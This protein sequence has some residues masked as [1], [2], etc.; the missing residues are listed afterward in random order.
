V[1]ART[2]LTAA[3][4]AVATGAALMATAP[5]AASAAAAPS[6][7]VSPH[8]NLTNNQM[9]TVT[10]K[11]FTAAETAKSA[12]AAECSHAALASKSIAD[13]DVSSA[14]AVP[15]GKTGSGH[16]KFK[17]L[18][19]ANYKDAN[20]GKCGGKNACIITVVDNPFAP[21]QEAAGVISFA[22]PKKATHTKVTSKKTVHKGKKVTF[23]V[24]TTHKGAGRLSGTVT[25]TANGKKIG[26][27]KESK[28]GRA[29]V[30]V[31]FK[32]TGTFT[33]KARYAGNKGFKG[34]TGKEKIHVKS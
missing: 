1:R 8:R 9:V 4:M 2:T 25:F 3:A 23:T 30:S 11:G 6:V 18:T 15:I 27:A 33:I 21:T 26:K 12:T 19:G 13:C 28:T 10:A 31:K 5:L 7:T 20:G 34:S 14:T 24:K 29:H 16:V 17:I 32:K 22:G